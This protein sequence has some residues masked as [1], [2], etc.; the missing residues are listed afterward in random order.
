MDGEGGR[1]RQW[2]LRVR[3]C[4]ARPAAVLDPDL[5]AERDRV[6]PCG[7]EFGG[8]AKCRSVPSTL[9]DLGTVAAVNADHP[10]RL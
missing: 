4:G 5:N 1:D 7:D 6:E 3:E 2:A 10:D 8:S 9:Y